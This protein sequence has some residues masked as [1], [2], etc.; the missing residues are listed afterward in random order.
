MTR[1]RQ[2]YVFEGGGAGI[3]TD[4]AHDW[5]IDRLWYESADPVATGANFRAAIGRGIMVGGKMNGAGA[6][7]AENMSSW[8]T[9]RGFGPASS[10]ITCGA[11]FDNEPFDAAE[12]LALLKRWWQLRPLRYTALTWAP[13]QGGLVTAALAAAIRSRPALTI[14]VQAYVDNDGDELYPAWAPAAIDNLVNV[15]IPRAQ[16][17]CFL[18]VK[19]GV[20]I[21]YGWEGALWGFAQ[22]PP[23]PPTPL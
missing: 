16:I 14:I 1:V 11:L 3:D 23:E 13:F 22:L 9:A 5:D 7:L 18:G 2:A 19:A 15:G 12:I 20:Q 10:P 21:P 8:L 6:T 17:V 4:K